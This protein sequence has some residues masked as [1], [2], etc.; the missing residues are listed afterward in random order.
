MVPEEASKTR[1]QPNAGAGAY[2]FSLIFTRIF[3]RLK[4]H[5]A[6]KFCLVKK[7]LLRFL[8]P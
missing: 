5:W 6:D 8:P 1:L 2:F 4:R 7:S 3:T